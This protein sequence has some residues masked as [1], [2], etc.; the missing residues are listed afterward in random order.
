MKCFQHSYTAHLT[1]MLLMFQN[2]ETVSPHLLTLVFSPISV[3]PNVKPLP[4]DR[5]GCVSGGVAGAVA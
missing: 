2:I 1:L 3:F 4:P 5:S